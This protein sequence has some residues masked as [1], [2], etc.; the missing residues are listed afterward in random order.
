MIQAYN[1]PAPSVRR[2][3]TFNVRNYSSIVSLSCP[4]P[5]PFIFNQ[6]LAMVPHLRGAI[7]HPVHRLQSVKSEQ[8]RVQ[9]ISFLP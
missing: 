8:R 9:E 7:M 1:H 2:F 4:P 5:P 3:I 6:G